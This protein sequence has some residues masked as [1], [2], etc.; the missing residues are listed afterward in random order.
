M[1]PGGLRE[2]KE[3]FNKCHPEVSRTAKKKGSSW[4]ARECSD[5]LVRPSQNSTINPSALQDSFHDSFQTLQ[6]S[7]PLSPP[8]C[9][10]AFVT[11]I[12]V[13]LG[14]Y[15]FGLHVFLR[16]YVFL[17][18]GDMFLLVVFIFGLPGN[19][20]VCFCSFGVLQVFFFGLLVVS[21]A[22]FLPGNDLNGFFFFF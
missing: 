11:V 18:F 13:F 1:P 10:P 5:L 16:R 22:F 9:Q 7:P 14:I 20:M 2:R 8:P 4:H 6:D 17:L 12:G 15:L 3:Q 21:R 19:S